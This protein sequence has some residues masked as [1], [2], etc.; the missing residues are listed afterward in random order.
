MSSDLKDI[1]PY[2]EAAAGN[3]L[4]LRHPVTGDLLYH[5]GDEKKPMELLVMG[6]LAPKIR[7]LSEALERKSRVI[8]ET[9]RV[10]Y[11]EQGQSKEEA[12]IN[13][14][15]TLEEKDNL[16]I[17]LFS[18]ALMDWKN[19]Q[20]NGKTK[21]TPAL[22]KKMLTERKWLLPQLADFSKKSVPGIG[23]AKAS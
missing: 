3:W 23:G 11:L 4:H 21:L 9:R 19:T 20:F 6:Y 8:Q 18:Q 15:L 1:D 10:E 14:R 2:G 7:K 13:S 17:E 12:F 22:A 16:D 5:N